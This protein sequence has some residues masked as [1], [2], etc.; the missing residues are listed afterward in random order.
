M[1]RLSD[2]LVVVRRSGR[3]VHAT[4]RLGEE[5][6]VILSYRLPDGDGV[7]QPVPLGN[8]SLSV[9][10]ELWWALWRDGEVKSFLGPAADANGDRWPDVSNVVVAKF[11][12]QSRAP[13]QFHVL[14]EKDAV[15]DG[16]AGVLPD[17]TVLPTI[18]YSVSFE[19][20]D[21]EVDVVSLVAGF[22][23]GP[24]SVGVDES[25]IRVYG[26]RLPS[27]S[28]VGLLTREE[29][30]D[31]TSTREGL[32][33]GQRLSQAAAANAVTRYYKRVD[34]TSANV[35]PAAPRQMGSSGFYPSQTVTLA[36]FAAVTADEAGSALLTASVDGSYSHTELGLVDCW[37]ERTA[38]DGTVT[39]VGTHSYTTVW[40]LFVGSQRGTATL[41]VPAEL[42]AGDVIRLRCRVKSG[43]AGNAYTVNATYCAMTGV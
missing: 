35:T 24:R 29:A 3:P 38:S 15:P 8:H 25:P 19:D 6:P 16:M 42:A 30:E 23:Y 11:P 26:R 31:R 22:R 4:Y 39:E 33:T 32:I 12:D 5:L 34:G 43:A 41:L 10:A 2:T 40:G 17:A 7:L 9:K 21:S 1:G 27:A 20:A 14:V 36:E 18:I 37:F 28:T 13:G